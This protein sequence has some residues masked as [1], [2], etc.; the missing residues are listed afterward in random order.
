M[1]FAPYDVTAQDGT[2]L[3][4]TAWEEISSLRSTCR[5]AHLHVGA[6]GKVHEIEDGLPR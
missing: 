4:T 5:S 3:T 6:D 2:K 1:D